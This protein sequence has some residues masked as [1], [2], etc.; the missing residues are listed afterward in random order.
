MGWPV[1]CVRRRKGA[2]VDSPEPILAGPS[3]RPTHAPGRDVRVNASRRPKSVLKSFSQAGSLSRGVTG[4]FAHFWTQ[5][6]LKSDL[7]RP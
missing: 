5:G 6:V 2:V 1:D 4:F 7:S 3:T